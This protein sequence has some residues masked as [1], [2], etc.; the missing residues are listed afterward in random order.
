MK[1]SSFPFSRSLRSRELLSCYLTPSPQ[2]LISG[3]I[4]LTGDQLDE[5]IKQAQ[6]GSARAYR[7]DDVN[8]RIHRVAM[9][10]A[11]MCTFAV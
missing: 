10:P 1:N 9:S 7:T 4:A 8:S 5:E 6:R 3:F 2:T 11:G